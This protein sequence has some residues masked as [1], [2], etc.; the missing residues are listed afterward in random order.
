MA[1]YEEG[2]VVE[3]PEV[4]QAKIVESAKEVRERQLDPL[5]K[6]KI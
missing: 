5:E 4:L 2:L 3:N 1:E 6:Q